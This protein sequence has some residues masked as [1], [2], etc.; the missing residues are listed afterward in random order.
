MRLCHHGRNHWI[1]LVRRFI[2]ISRKSHIATGIIINGK[3]KS[4]DSASVYRLQ[5]HT[6]A[7]KR[8]SC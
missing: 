1:V 7:T 5:L 4:A 6:R 2:V 3:I 8:Y